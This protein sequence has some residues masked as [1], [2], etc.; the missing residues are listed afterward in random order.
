MENFHK[1]K[2]IGFI[3]GTIHSGSALK[4][5]HKLAAKASEHDGSFFVFPGGKLDT[6]A[7][8]GEIRNKIYSLAN[9]ENI[10]GLISWASSL[11]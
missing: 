7:E 9:S 1:G 4:L 11:S 8:S 2:R 5:W 6:R 3:L 10:D